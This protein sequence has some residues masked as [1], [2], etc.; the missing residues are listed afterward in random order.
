MKNKIIVI[1]AALLFLDLFLSINQAYCDETPKLLV[2][3]SPGCHRC[4]EVK[5]NILPQVEKEFEGS[6]NIHYYDITDIKNYAFMFGLKEKYD[7]D[8][9]LALPVFFINGRLI[10]GKGD[11]KNN[12]ELA[13]YASLGETH[14]ENGGLKVDLVSRFKGFSPFAIA[15]AGLTDGINPCAF[16][17]IV[18]FI[19][20]LA[21]QGY[22]KLE[23]I[24]IGFS[25]IFS[26]FCTYL[27]IGLGIFNFLYQLEGFWALARAFNILI[28]IFSLIL[29]ALAVYDLVKFNK[30]KNP[31]GLFLQLPRAV[32]NQIHSIIGAHYRKTKDADTQKPVVLRL[33]RLILSALITGFL[34]S[35][36]EAVC[37]GQLYLPTI[38]FI[39]KTTSLKLKAFTYL[40]LYNI[41]FIVPLFIIFLFALLGV[42]SQQFAEFIRKHMTGIKALM[43]VVFI[44]LGVLLIWRG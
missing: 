13:I 38:A 10:N 36:L 44:A 11:V 30:D 7:K 32:K 29:G 23:L 34:V 24:I 26:V 41:M 2:F 18:F 9:E 16:T 20:F 19:S 3:H 35:L 43:A 17:V 14:K 15:G 40:A 31:E 33:G 21:L 25:F 8:F 37:T 4:L 22:R 12:L 42:T 28:G 5:K 6:I 39:L 27:L 1:L